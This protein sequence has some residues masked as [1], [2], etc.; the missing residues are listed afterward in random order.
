[1][2]PTPSDFSLNVLSNEANSLLEQ[3]K[4]YRALMDDLPPNDSRRAVY[5]GII[6]DLLDRSRRLSEAVIAGSRIS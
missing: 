6:R 2:R 3:A 1:M 5:E 4:T